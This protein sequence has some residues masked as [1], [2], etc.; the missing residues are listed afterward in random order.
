MRIII[1]G[2]SG[3]VGSLLSSELSKAGHEVIILSRSPE[4]NRGR[5]GEGI[6]VVGWDGKTSAG[7]GSLV[8]EADAIVNLAGENLA[9]DSLL[10]S[11]WTSKRKHAILESRLQPGNAI[12]E[13][14]QQAH[15]KP[16]LLIQSSAVGYYGPHSDEVIT[17][18]AGPQDDFLSQV[19]VQWEASTEDVEKSGVR[20][21]VIR[22][23]VILDGKQGS[24]PRMVLP[25]KFFV[26]GPIGSGKQW[27]SYINIF[28]VVKGICFLLEHEEASGVY[29][30]TSPNPVTNKELEKAIG[31]VMNRPSWFPVPA[32]VMKLLFG[33]MSTV[34][35]D[36]QRVLPTRLTEAGFSFDYPDVVSSLQ[37]VLKP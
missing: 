1:S 32:F 26:G 21:A 25:F 27:V 5:Y 31:K 7:W 35:L 16:K 23:G 15:K 37:A 22:T 14:I 30:L 36:G 3:M 2:G 8:E 6:R 19:C 18:E 34:L 20:R 13:A 9:G 29:N 28:D 11:R 4:K 24:L 17:E 33:E 10:P 12:V